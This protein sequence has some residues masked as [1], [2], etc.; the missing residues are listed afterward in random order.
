MFYYIRKWNIFIALENADKNIKADEVIESDIKDWVLVNGKIIS[1]KDTDEYK[2]RVADI[3][4][5]S[6]KEF[7]PPTIEEQIAK[8]QEDFQ[9]KIDEFNAKYP[10]A[11][12]ARFTDKLEKAKAVIA[13]WT[14]DYITAK[15]VYL[16]IQ[17][18]EFAQI[19]IDKAAA[20]EAFYIEA[21]NVRDEAIDALKV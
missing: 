7:E 12:Q 16:W 9:I 11:E 20:F 21:E 2:K 6:R 19:I 4:E 14:D 10:A 1:Y 3:E 8:I 15:A 5:L 17:D 13:W 18:I